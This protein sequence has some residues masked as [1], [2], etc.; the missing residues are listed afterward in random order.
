MEV[1]LGKTHLFQAVGNHIR[2]LNPKARILYQSADRFVH[3]FITAIRFDKVAAFEQRYREVDVLLIDDLQFIARKEQTQ[4]AFFH[5]FNAL[6]ESRKQIVFSSDT[7]P[8][9][10]EGLAQRIRSRL[11]GALITDIQ[12]PCME[13]K[14]A[15]LQKKAD[16]QKEVLTDDV[17]H[18]I[19]HGSKTMC[20]SWKG[21]LFVYLRLQ[22]LPIKQY[23]WI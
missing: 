6:Y 23:H 16:M 9:N 2:E 11:D 22:R 19:A 4:E 17:A 13:T 10:I 7:L 12:P 20:A 18:F 8:G 1:G 14:I 3:E 15:I 5:I 21:C